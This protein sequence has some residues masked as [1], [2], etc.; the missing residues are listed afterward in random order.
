VRGWFSLAAISEEL[1]IDGKELI[2]T[3]GEPNGG[4]A[5]PTIGRHIQKAV[6]VPYRQ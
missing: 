6:R 2:L 5:K 4:L 3:W 1:A